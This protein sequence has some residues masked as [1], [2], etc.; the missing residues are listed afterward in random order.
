MEKLFSPMEAESW[1]L[2]KNDFFSFT[3]NYF[4]H[5]SPR[6]CGI[7]IADNEFDTKEGALKHWHFCGT[8]DGKFIS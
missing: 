2:F 7:F 8:G 3:F 4:S 1:W 6:D 5:V